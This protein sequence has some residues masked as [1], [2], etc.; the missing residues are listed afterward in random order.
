MD[1]INVALLVKA[2]LRRALRV[3]ITLDDTTTV[4]AATQQAASGPHISA[5]SL[6][7]QLAPS[8]EVNVV[9][10]LKTVN[11]HFSKIDNMPVHMLP[12]SGVWS[13]MQ[14][15]N[16]AATASSR[17]H[18]ERVAAAVDSTRR[19][20]WEDRLAW[21]FR[22]AAQWGSNHCHTQRVWQGIASD[23]GA[24]VLPESHTM[25]CHIPAL[26]PGGRSDESVLAR[27]AQGC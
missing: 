20:W 8:K 13:L 9:E 16:D 17:T 3:I 24:E 22:L 15:E 26:F 18:I 2:F 25:G 14:A 6:A 23:A 19:S 27:V 7:L 10:K 11:P 4:A 5:A 12:E 21:R 1:A